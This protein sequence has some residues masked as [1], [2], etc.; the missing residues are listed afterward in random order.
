MSTPGV[1]RDPRRYRMTEPFLTHPT[2]PR[3]LSAHLFE[4]AVGVAW[5]VVAIGYLSDPS[6]S[7]TMSPVGRTLPGYLWLTWS[8]LEIVGGASLVIGLLHGRT[9]LRVAGLIALSTGLGM[10]GAAAILSGFDIRDL[11][12]LLYAATCSL[13]ALTVTRIVLEGGPDAR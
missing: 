4:L 11:V 1:A 13:R 6:G 8:L 7:L 9:N 12:Y 5:A 3:R 2:L 10:H